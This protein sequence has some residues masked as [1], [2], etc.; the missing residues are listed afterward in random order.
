M[1]SAT[2]E[3]LLPD[4]L[5]SSRTYRR[6]PLNESLHLTP[7]EADR[8]LESDREKYFEYVNRSCDLTMRGGTTSGVIYPLAACAL[9][10]DFMFRSVGG[11]SAGAIAAAFTAAA[12]HGRFADGEVKADGGVRPGFAGL[13]DL[14]DWFTSGR[15]DERWRLAQ[16]FQPGEHTRKLYR[17]LAAS[18][19]RRVT[20]G[21]NPLV[22]L[23]VA[24]LGATGPRAK[25]ALGFVL[26]LWVAGPSGVALALAQLRWALVPAVVVAALAL[27]AP[28]VV[29]RVVSAMPSNG[30]TT[31]PWFHRIGPAVAVL[32]P[33]IVAVALA[34][35]ATRSGTAPA[36]LGTVAAAVLSWLVLT[37][38]A[39]SGLALTYALAANRFLTDS[40]KSIHF[41]LV[42]GTS[43]TGVPFRPNVWDRLSGVP[44]S[45]GVPPLSDWL[46]D[47]LDDL[48]GTAGGHALTFGDLWAGP[49][50]R[51]APDAASR[52]GRRVVNLVLM[53]TD[54]SEERPYR[55][56]FTD[57]VSS[58]SFCPD[59]L[60]VVLPERVVKQ[61]AASGE[62]VRHRCPVHDDTW[63]HELP[64]AEQLPVVFAV[65]MS[66]PLPGLIAAVPLYRTDTAVRTHWFS[67]GGLT[68]NFPIHLFDSLLPRW[69]TFG[70]N[71]QPYPVGGS[72]QDVWLPRQNAS[73]RGT[74]WLKI[75]T[76]PEFLQAMLN[77]VLGWRDTAQSAMPGYRGRIAHVRRREDEGGT[78]LFMAPETIRTLADRG[79]RAGEMIRD[80][81][82]GENGETD[83]YRWIRMRIAMREYRELATQ[84]DQRN[85]LYDEVVEHFRVPA[86]LR[87]WFR[88]PPDGHD[89]CAL[90]VE[91]TIDALG[92]LVEPGGPLEKPVDGVPPVDPDLRLTPP[93]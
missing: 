6:A 28:V 84:A 92:N 37:F 18:M 35:S 90:Q 87:S 68:S 11:A 34:T 69:P 91:R 21:R 17:L 64:P 46:A 29:A 15:G 41:G 42:P 51:P 70:L 86:E 23:F 9:A 19:Q 50:G 83:R 88:D 25:A 38:A 8:L 30:K 36:V 62:P 75:D 71:I 65:R 79:H 47:R 20:T 67:D 2:Q 43:P 7:D 72:Q 13:V 80:R 49:G 14:V 58:W 82:A 5:R 63:L 74:P 4:E 1:D 73:T 45:T 77:T 10:R 78:N 31:T 55:I 26:T 54:I 40:A 22:C 57:P 24:L 89:P 66:L 48:A 61:M 81:F 16:L 53:T 85:E 27:S 12:E 44:K 52:S 56:P 33:V 60:R 59:C 39:V 3:A 32:G 76:L 93:E